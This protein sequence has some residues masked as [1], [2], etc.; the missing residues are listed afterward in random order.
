[1]P[2]SIEEQIGTLPAVKAETHLFEVSGEM[3]CGNPV[4]TEWRPPR[5]CKPDDGDNQMNEKDDDIA[6]PRMISKSEKT[7]NFGSIQ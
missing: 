4:P 2:Q 6:H 5:P 3:F 7:S 1:M